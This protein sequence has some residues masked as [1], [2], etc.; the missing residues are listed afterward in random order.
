MAYEIGYRRPPKHGQFRKG[1]SGNPRGRPKGSKNLLT[2]LE[3]ELSQPITVSENGKKQT[4]TRLQAMVKR[5]VSDG[6]QGNLKSLMT[7]F[8][9]LRRSGKLE[10]TDIE[11]LLPADYEDILDNYISGRQK[12]VSTKSKFNKEG[13]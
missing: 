11:S 1:R 8:E 7:V 13:V 2:L 10:E 3:K 6:L 9:I 4:I 5:I 12:Q